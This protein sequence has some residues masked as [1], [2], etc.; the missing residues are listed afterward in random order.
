MNHRVTL[1]ITALLTIVLASFHLADDVV[2]GIEPGGTT[3]YTGIVILAVWLYSTLMLGERRWAHALVLIGSLG[4][5]AVA[6]LHMT[7]SGLVGPRIVNSGAVFFWV[8]TLFALGTTGIVSV[9]LA[10]Q[11]LWTIQRRHRVG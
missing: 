6:Y 11:R 4:G 7:G 10:A 8:W 2:R 3:N 1:T 5:A 9:V